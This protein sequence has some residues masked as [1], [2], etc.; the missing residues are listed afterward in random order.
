MIVATSKHAAS[1]LGEKLKDRE[2]DKE[3]L[4]ICQGLPKGSLGYRYSGSLTSSLDFSP[5]ERRYSHITRNNVVSSE[6]T[7]KMATTHFE[8]IGVIGIDKVGVRHYRKH[9]VGENL[10]HFESKVSVNLDCHDLISIVRF[11]IDT[12]KKHQIRAH[13]SQILNAPL[14]LDY[15]YGYN[16]SAFKSDNFKTLLKNYPSMFRK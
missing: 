7:G 10:H 2:V 12:G 1:A 14:I 11:K 8:V 9:E 16:E 6:V 13:T 5:A 3:Y 15:K 4:G